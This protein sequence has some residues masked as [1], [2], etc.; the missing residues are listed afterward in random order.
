MRPLAAT[1]ACFVATLIAVP[2][3]GQTIPSPYEFIE[4]RQ[5]FEILVTHFTEQRGALGLGP[6]GG[7]ALGARFGWQISGPLALEG[8]ASL[9]PT[10]RE[11]RV[12]DEE[13]GLDNLGSADAL[14]GTLDARVRF[15]L[16]GN[17]TWHRL[18]PYLSAGAGMAFDVEGRSAL[19]EEIPQSVRFDFGPSFLG[20]LGAGVR[21]L[22]A[23]RITVR[24]EAS[25]NYWKLGTPQTFLE[26]GEAVIGQP[27]P[28]QEWAPVPAFS[29]G[30]SWRR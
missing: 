30:I 28:E 25:V 7:M 5:E 23:D 29:L 18:A 3:A 8:N 4:E 15:S 10:D 9:L 26:Q 27:V 20:I 12:P 6:G 13:S 17:R 2:V 19:E 14:V 21:F 11:V 1:F 16:A 22:P 24:A